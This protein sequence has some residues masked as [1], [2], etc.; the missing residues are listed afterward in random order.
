MS[1]WFEMYAAQPNVRRTACPA[2]K[3]P[4]TAEGVTG[5]ARRSLHSTPEKHRC[6]GRD[7]RAVV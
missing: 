2:R 4:K 5:G 7:D 3:D 1:P 6:S